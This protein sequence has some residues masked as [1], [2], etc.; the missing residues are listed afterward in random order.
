MSENTKI[1]WATHSWN[2]WRG[3][4]KV[5][6][7]CANCYAETLTMNRMGGGK[8]IKGTPRNKITRIELWYL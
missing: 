3:C 7:G 4:T 5:S 8:Y 6:P 1:E 2:P